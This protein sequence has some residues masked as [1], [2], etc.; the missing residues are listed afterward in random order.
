MPTYE[1]R[2]P[3]GH[4]VE[5][6]VRKISD[7]QTEVECPVCGKVAPRRMSLGGGLLFK[8]SGF[9]LTDYGKNAHRGG[10]PE[11]SGGG[12]GGGGESKSSGEGG[13]KSESAS[14]GSPAASSGS[15]GGGESSSGAKSSAEA[16]PAAEPKKAAEPKPAPPKKGDA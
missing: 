16:K 9:Y 4:E 14:A 5:R 13:A 15:G 11:K 6:F 3:D 10:A 12:G 7:A 2:C 8:G 1:Y